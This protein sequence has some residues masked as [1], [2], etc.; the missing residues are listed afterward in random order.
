MDTPF[1][2]MDF[3]F[4]MPMFFPFRSMHLITCLVVSAEVMAEFGS[5]V[6]FGYTFTVQSGSRVGLGGQAATAENKRGVLF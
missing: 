1:L 5:L 4:L 3:M 6:D 2:L